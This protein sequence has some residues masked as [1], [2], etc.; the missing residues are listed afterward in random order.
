MKH[1]RVTDSNCSIGDIFGEPL[2][3]LRYYM[4]V[5]CHSVNMGSLISKFFLFLYGGQLG[6]KMKTTWKIPEADENSEAM[7]GKLT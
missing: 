5:V 4:H 2:F 1:N 7:Q 6:V 3:Y